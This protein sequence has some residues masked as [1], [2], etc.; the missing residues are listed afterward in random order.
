MKVIVHTRKCDARIVSHQHQNFTH[1]SA[2]RI[3]YFLA[4]PEKKKPGKDKKKGM[5]KPHYHN[6]SFHPL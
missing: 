2:K 3:F 5:F 1:A 4:K 6:Q